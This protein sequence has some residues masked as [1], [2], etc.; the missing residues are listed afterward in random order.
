MVIVN[1]LLPPLALGVTGLVPNAR[2]ACAGKLE[3]ARVTTLEFVPPSDIILIVYCALPPCATVCVLVGVAIAKSTP[4]PDRGTAC[5]LPATWLLLSVKV[6]V[7]LRVPV[8]AGVRS[9]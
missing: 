8:V 1:V 3:Q 7:A 6:S 5:V 4:T 9:R 2:V